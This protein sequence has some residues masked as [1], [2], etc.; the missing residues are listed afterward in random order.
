[1]L[2]PRPQRAAELQQF[3]QVANSYSKAAFIGIGSMAIRNIKSWRLATAK[4]SQSTDPYKNLFKSNGHFAPFSIPS[5]LMREASVVGFMLSNLAAP[6]GPKILPPLCFSAA[7]M[8]S[9]S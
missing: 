7:V 9:R 5:A 1:M 2:V 8:L 6:P 3:R 4:S